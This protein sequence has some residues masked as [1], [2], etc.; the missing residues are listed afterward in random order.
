[1]MMYDIDMHFDSFVTITSDGLE[2]ITT[3]FNINTLKKYILYVCIEFIH[4]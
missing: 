2:Y 1:M 4:V 3:T